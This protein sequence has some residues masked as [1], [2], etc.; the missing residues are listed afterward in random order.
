MLNLQHIRLASCLHV[1]NVLRKGIIL[2]DCGHIV[3]RTGSE[4]KKRPLNCLGAIWVRL[5][6][7]EP[8]ELLNDIH[9]HVVKGALTVPLEKA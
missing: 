7:I 2:L 8:E 1:L 9:T 4:Y 5:I 6:D 3:Q